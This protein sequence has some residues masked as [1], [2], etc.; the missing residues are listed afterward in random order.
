MREK[1]T[2][3]R[4]RE[5][6]LRY[7]HIREDLDLVDRKGKLKERHWGKEENKWRIRKEDHVKL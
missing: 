6:F 7:T 4:K 2:F 3:N 1:I 5:K